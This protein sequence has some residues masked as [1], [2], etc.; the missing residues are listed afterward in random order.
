MPFLQARTG[1]SRV[2]MCASIRLMRGNLTGRER[3]PKSVTRNGPPWLVLFRDC[4]LDN[5]IYVFFVVL[6]ER[7]ATVS[8]R[9]HKSRPFA[10]IATSAG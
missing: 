2:H 7:T 5:Y 10:P 6:Y 8:L 4:L 9:R 1:P 3:Q